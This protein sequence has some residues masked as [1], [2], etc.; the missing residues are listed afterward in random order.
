MDI[1]AFLERAAIIEFDGGMSRFRA[2]TLAAQAQGRQRREF[3]DEISRR[4]SSGQR[5]Q[6]EALQRDG[7]DNLPGVQPASAQQARHLSQR[8]VQA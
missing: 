4:N 2:E 3:L 6:R 7:S 8:D 5:H 1:D